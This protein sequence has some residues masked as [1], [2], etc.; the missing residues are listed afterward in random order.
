MF[1]RYRRVHLRNS[2]PRPFGFL[3]RPIVQLGILAIAA[4]AIFYIAMTAGK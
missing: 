2:Q 3:R 4:L 1:R